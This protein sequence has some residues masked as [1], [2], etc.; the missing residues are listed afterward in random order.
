MFS[1][2]HATGCEA[3]YFTTDGYGIFN[4]RTLLGACHTHEGGSGTNRSTQELTRRDRKTVA[5]PAPAR[6][7]NPPGSS[8]LNSNHWA[9]SLGNVPKYAWSNTF[10]DFCSPL[11]CGYVIKQKFQI[12]NLAERLKILRKQEERNPIDLF[13]KKKR[14]KSYSPYS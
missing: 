1:C 2:F 12:T 9:T 10:Y 4:V 14:R 5:H 7:S 8:D 6:G 11:A 13:R 3:Y